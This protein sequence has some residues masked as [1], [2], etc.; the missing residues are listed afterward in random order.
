M[1][2]WDHGVLIHVF[3][4][5]FLVGGVASSIIRAFTRTSDNYQD[6]LFYVLTHAA[7]PPLVWLVGLAAC[8]VPI[9][10]SV[11]PPAM[12]DRDDLLQREEGTK[13]AHPTEKAKQPRWGKSNLLHEGCYALV[14][15]YVSILFIGSWFY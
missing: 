9:K 7:W 14:T 11:C 3:Y 4:L 6:R 10:Y 2:W 12:P 8:T 5:L 15:I 13:I 1:I